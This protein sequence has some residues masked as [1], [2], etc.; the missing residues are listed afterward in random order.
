MASPESLAV[1]VRVLVTPTDDGFFLAE[2]L[3]G[4]GLLEV[5]RTEEE[6]VEYVTLALED[7]L[8]DSPELRAGLGVK[9]AEDLAGLPLGKVVEVAV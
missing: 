4:E 9:R 7:L 3:G 1:S 6:A 5:G 2:S 8:A